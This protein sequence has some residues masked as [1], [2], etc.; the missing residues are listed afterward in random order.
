MQI[1]GF[2]SLGR[3]AEVGGSLVL[4]CM[5]WLLVS[6]LGKPGGREADSSLLHGAHLCFKAPAVAPD[7]PYVKFIN[8]WEIILAWEI[9][10]PNYC[11]GIGVLSPTPWKN[12]V[13]T[14]KQQQW[15]HIARWQSSCVMNVIQ[16]HL[17]PAQTHS[18]RASSTHLS[19]GV[20]SDTWDSWLSTHPPT[21]SQ[22]FSLPRRSGYRV[23]REPWK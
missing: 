14:I 21:S 9:L 15:A 16:K 2:G 20:R 10:R 17:P 18:V 11:D 4:F 8:F 13:I 23:H 22:G 1:H 12:P 5:F 19:R 7:L 3:R 6:H